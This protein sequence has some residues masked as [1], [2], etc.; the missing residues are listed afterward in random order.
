MYIYKYINL[1]ITIKIHMGI[2]LLAQLRERW[3]RNT[4]AYIKIQVH[5]NTK[6]LYIYIKYIVYIYIYL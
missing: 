6:I 5:L 4:S 2:Y 3:N 1:Y